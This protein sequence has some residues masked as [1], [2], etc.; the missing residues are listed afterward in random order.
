MN[1]TNRLTYD[2][3]IINLVAKMRLAQTEYF[4]T[5]DKQVLAKYKALEKQVDQEIFLLLNP[6]DQQ[7][8]LLD[9]NN[10]NN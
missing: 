10:K 2:I 1:K 9:L 3:E 7:L 8:N 4:R 5:R 6:Q